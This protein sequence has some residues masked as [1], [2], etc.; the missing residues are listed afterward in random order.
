MRGGRVVAISNH[1]IIVADTGNPTGGYTDADYQNI[2]IQFDSVYAMD[3][4][5]FG[6]PTDIDSN[7]HIVL[8][9]TRAVNELTPPHS[10]SVVGGFFYG[11]DLFPRSDTPDIEGC[12]SSN[13]AEMFYL[14][15]PDPNG[16]VNQNRFSTASVSLLTVSTTAHEFQH[17]INASRRLYINNAP[18]FEETWLNEGLSHIAEELLFYQQSGLSPLMNIDSA[19]LFSS[20]RVVDAF[21]NDQTQNFNRYAQYLARPTSTSPYAHD[22]SLWTRGATWSFLRYA[23]DHRSAPE[24]DTWF[25]LV[26]TTSTGIQNLMNVFG[27][28]VSSMFRDWAI[29]TFTDD[30]PGVATEWLQPS[31]NFRALFDCCSTS[32]QHIYPLNYQTVGTGGS[33]SV[34]LHGGSS[35]YVRFAVA[36]GQVG[37]VTW[38]RLPSNVTMS[39]VRLK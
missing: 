12:P 23:A 31:W 34:S 3:T 25:R 13:V 8:F 24:N 16:V 37:N 14:L 21:K 5:A 9:F 22:D 39:I 38:G 2:A 26:N 29:A 18:Q 33:T 7:G 11:R 35:A 27:S 4:T 19:T 17:L 30:V 10:G 6:G 15:V 28:G 1:A 20:Q 36:A 32:G